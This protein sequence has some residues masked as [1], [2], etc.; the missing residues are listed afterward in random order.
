[1]KIRQQDNMHRT[2][3]AGIGAWLA[4]LA[5]A[6]A[7]AWSVALPAA[8]ADVPRSGV[9]TVLLEN[10]FFYGSDR[11]YTNGL[12]FLWVP[13]PDSAPDLAV[14]MARA[15]PWFPDTGLVRHGYALGQNI[16]TPGDI[17]LAR[18]PADDRP[19]AG[20]LYGTIGL[21]VD[22]GRQFDQVAFTLGMIGPASLAG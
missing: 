13:V 5:I 6:V 8:A 18:P 14:R 3:A 7:A 20:W 22:A 12:G 11:D 1:M 2:P 17:T 15:L 9:L 10:D 16:Y 4:A 21:G 19:Y